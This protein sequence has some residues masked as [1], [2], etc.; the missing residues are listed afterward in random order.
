MKIDWARMLSPTDWEHVVASL[1]LSPGQASFLWHALHDPRD[2][3]IAERMA[4]SLHG[5]HAHR[6]AVFRKLRVDSMPA[7]IAQVFAAYVNIRNGQASH[8]SVLGVA[9]DHT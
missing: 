7:A 5:A 1:K 3:F 6:M 2:A 9:S 8:A 4:V